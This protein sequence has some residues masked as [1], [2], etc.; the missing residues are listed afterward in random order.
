[1]TMQIV[2]MR[3]FSPYV[4][5]KW[6]THK[7]SWIELERQVSII[8]KQISDDY[9]DS[10]GN[11]ILVGILKGSYMFLSDL[12]KSVL[13]I[14]QI[15]FIKVSSYDGTESSGHIK[16]HLDIQQDIRGK[17]IVIVEDIIDTGRTMSK[18]LQVLKKRNPKSISVC[19]LFDKPQRRVVNDFEIK[20]KGIELENDDFVVGYGLDYNQY[21]R[22]LE[23]VGVPTEEALKVFE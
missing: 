10:D 8:A 23:F 13:P 22:D 12:S 2:R 19:S 14:H 7:Y 5:N 21:F 11:L 9:Q 1:M 3:G 15:E 4:E 6:V 18:L 16:I 20:Y 17:N